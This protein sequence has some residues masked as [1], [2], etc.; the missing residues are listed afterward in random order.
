MSFRWK[1]FTAFMATALSVI[2]AVGILFDRRLRL[3][4]L[5]EVEEVLQRQARAVAEFVPQDQNLSDPVLVD[6]LADRFGR[7]LGVRVTILSADGSVLGD[8][9][10]ATDALAGI[11]NHLG[12]PEV[13]QAIEEGMGTSI[14]Y[15]TTVGNDLIYVAIRKPVGTASRFKVVRLA[16]PLT[17]YRTMLHEWRT[18]LPGAIGVGIVLAFTLSFYLAAN[19]SRRISILDRYSSALASGQGAPEPPLPTGRDEI[20]RLASGMEEMGVRIREQMDRLRDEAGRRE[21]LFAA[22][23]EAIAAWDADGKLIV[24]NMAF[25]RLMQMDRTPTGAS[26]AEVLRDAALIGM[27]DDAARGRAP[28]ERE[29][30]FSRGSIAALRCRFAPIHG[31]GA[32]AGVMVIFQDITHIRKTEE[33]RRDFV[34]NAAHEIKTPLASILG[35]AETLLDGASRDERHR[36]DFILRIH[37]NAKRLSRLAEDLLTLGRIESG[38]WPIETKP[39]AIESLVRGIFSSL[40]REMDARGIRGS[41]AIPPDASVIQGDEFALEQILYNLIDNAVKYNRP[42]GSVTVTIASGP[43]RTTLSIE[44][45]GV[46]IPAEDQPRIFER[47]YRVDKTRSREMGGTGL[48]LSI[49]KHLVM[50]QEGKV[51][52]ESQPG[53]GTT[54]H[55][56]IPGQLVEGH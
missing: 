51:E 23:T 16:L 11:E 1:L 42:G 35:F 29:I 38:Q 4:L 30:S 40:Q 48:G 15:S 21:T 22:M 32:S 52:V 10:V 55:V 46:G 34:L 43:G 47:F 41:V 49:V 37:S 45:T 25:L 14:R 54:F 28:V 26:A 24:A 19:L 12:R 13:R 7:T 53:R 33:I 44:D 20:G 50:A 56:I 27:Y 6:G 17:Q 8:S 31:D 39:V 5:E 9:D 2:A 18:V 36:D 3:N